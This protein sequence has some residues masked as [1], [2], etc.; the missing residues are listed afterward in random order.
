MYKNSNLAKSIRLAL[1][2]GGASLALTGTAAAQ[3]QSE[4]EQA[5]EAQERITVTGS[6]ITRTDYESASPVQITSSEEIKVSGFTKIEDLMNSLPK[7]RQRK[8][9]TFLTAL[10]VQLHLTF[11]VW[12][13]SVLWCS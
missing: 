9:R 1:M 12:V 7:S 10:Q 2:F 13:Q 5:E 8:L 6:R 3:D 4:E 11:V